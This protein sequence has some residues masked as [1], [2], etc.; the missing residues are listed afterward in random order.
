MGLFKKGHIPWNKGVKITYK[1]GMLGRKHTAETRMKISIAN[2][3]KKKPPFT[4]DHKRHLRE[5]H[6]GM[7]GKRVSE[8]TKRKMSKAHKGDKNY[9]YGRKMTLTQRKVLSETHFGYKQSE[10]QI[11]KRNISLQKFFKS[12]RPTSIERKLYKELEDRHLLFETQKLINGKFLVD[13][14]IKKLNLIIEADG[15]YW[16]SLPRVM[17][18]DKAENAY[19]TKCGYNLLRLSEKE[20]NDDS[21]KERMVFKID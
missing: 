12:K 15:D 1:N 10:E 18:K 7:L 19:L 16:H 13:A 3:G 9:W 6:K 21:F 4:K 8:E 17:K 2:K 20:I 14:Y 5:N 11:Q